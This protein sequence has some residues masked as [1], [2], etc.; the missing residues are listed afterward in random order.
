MVSTAPEFPIPSRSA[1]GFSSQIPVEIFHEPCKLLCVLGP[2]KEVI[3]VGEELKAEDLNAEAALG[4]THH[5][6]YDFV[7]LRG[8]SKQEAT[9]DGPVRHFHESPALRDIPW[10]SSHVLNRRKNGVTSAVDSLSF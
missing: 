4:P 10:L 5:T 6:D 9:L 2:R 7:Q 1:S 8:R 3:V